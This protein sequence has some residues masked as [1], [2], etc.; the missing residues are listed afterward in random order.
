MTIDADRL[1]ALLPA[2]YRIRDAEMGG[3]LRAF[4]A[5][6][7]EQAAVVEENLEQLYDDQF[8]ETCADWAAPYIGGVIGYRPL[9]GVT[10]TVASPRAEV[11]NTISYRRR[12]GTAAVLEQLAHDV[13]GWAA[14]VVEFFQ[15]VAT[16][17]YMNHIR[18][19]HAVSPDLRDWEGLERIGTAFDPFTRAVDVRSTERAEGR[20]NLPNV[21]IFLWRLDPYRLHDS[22]AVAVDTRR[23]LISPLGHA[24]DLFTR[25]EAEEVITSLA[26]PLNVPA[27]I[28]RRA[29]AER[30][31]DY[32]CP[33][34]SIHISVGGTPVALADVEACNLADD[35]AGGW[36]H[37]PTDKVAIDPALGRIAFPGDVTDE[38]LV[39]FHYVFSAAMG[40]GEYERAA[41]FAIESGDMPR[42][43][44]PSVDHPTI[45]SAIDS[46]PATGG[47]VEIVDNGRYEEALAIVAAADATIELRAANGV[48][49]LIL[50]D[51]DMTITG[52]AG[53]RVILDGLV[54][55]R[56][57]IVVPDA[58]DNALD[59]FALRHVTLVP[60]RELDGP[61]NPVSPAEVS[62]RVEIA[63]LELAIDHSILGML[64]LAPKSAARIADS[65]VDATDPAGVAIAAPAATEP[66]HGFAGRLTI[67]AST[68]IGK[69]ASERL[70]LVSNAI[71]FAQLAEAA[72]T[73]PAPVRTARKQEGC[74]RF[75]YVPHG[76]IVPRRYRCQ[77]QLAI[78]QE[79]AAREKTLGGRISAR[80][81]ARIVARNARRIRPSYTSLR[82]GQPGYAQ[83]RRGTPLE[84]RTGAE[85]E[86]EMG[87]FH[88]L[89]QPQRETNLRIRLDEYLRFGLEAGLFFET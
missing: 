8:I 5:V 49:P 66:A 50:L 24:I 58:A 62:L 47:I 30:M 88:A 60:G 36:A 18:P 23:F 28:S 68:V 9:H 63:N 41:A 89:Y 35:G 87:A 34:K 31:P 10:A 6:L 74:L 39:T 20:Y 65:I 3:P 29:L 57:G 54:M 83:L 56:G 42:R 78:D 86:S 72:E 7:A 4:L 51:G 45:Q 27:P 80:E 40:G 81:R 19:D 22:P 73:W 44:V 14:R 75:S 17:Q 32:Y 85:D 15:L 25:P 64:R 82:Y 11:A 76:A 53:A 71:L 59:E 33:D 21:G 2:I 13:T 67:L 12:K 79:I 69:I 77:P 26:A 48:R 52:A 61:G 37:M 16:A 55:A 46:L 84:I 43:T 38:V 1:Y 70:E